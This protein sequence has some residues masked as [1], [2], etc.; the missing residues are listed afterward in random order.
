MKRIALFI[1][2]LITSCNGGNETKLNNNPKVVEL[3]PVQIITQLDSLF[4][5]RVNFF[6]DD[7]K[8]YVLSQ[9]PPYLAVTDK[10]FNLIK[11]VSGKNAGPEGFSMPVQGAST[12]G[13]V[14]IVDLGIM[15]LKKFDAN[16]GDFIS[17]VKIPEIPIEK[18]FEIDEEGNVLYPVFSP[19]NEDVIIKVSPDGN[20]I[21]RF[22]STFPN[23]SQ[24]KENRQMKYF[25]Q[26]ENGNFLLIGASLPYIDYLDSE[27]NTIN[28]FDL[29]E[30]EPVKRA[31]DS[32][33]YGLVKDPFPN[34]SIPVMILDAQYSSGKLYVSFTDRIGYDRSKARNLMVFKIDENICELEKLI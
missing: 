9:N 22:E 34:N 31:L 33:E 14:H 30:V 18:R 8:N 32:L 21:E 19:I 5:T 20:I 29:R 2:V 24:A 15:S 6:S 4:F 7:E 1:F 28:R 25:Q 26:D 13:L 16:S 12:Q 10:S 3:V 27:G 23:E 11:V 17:S